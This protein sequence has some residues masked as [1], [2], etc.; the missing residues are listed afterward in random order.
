MSFAQITCLYACLLQINGDDDEVLSESRLVVAQI[1]L[2]CVHCWCSCVVV[3][4]APQVAARE[5]ILANGGSVS[6]HHGG[7]KCFFLS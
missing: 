3:L 5:E 1:L 6:H 7:Q 2:L 4:F